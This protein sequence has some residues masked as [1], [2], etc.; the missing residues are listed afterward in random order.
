MNSMHRMMPMLWT[1]LAVAA[2]G[3]QAKEP[4][5]S[6]DQLFELDDEEEAPVPKAAPAPSPKATS[7]PSPSKASPSTSPKAAPAATANPS[8]AT[9]ASPAKSANPSGAPKPPGNVADAPSRPATANTAPAPT[10]EDREP[11]SVRRNTQPQATM[12]VTPQVASQQQDKT[13]RKNA[14]PV[15]WSGFAQEE[16]ARQYAKPSH[17][18][19]VRTRAQ[20][21]AQGQTGG[22]IKWK[23]GARVDYDAVFD[24]T[25]RYSDD[26]RKDRRLELLLRENYADIGAGP[27]ELR[28]GR[29]H[30]IWGE[31]VGLF[32]ADVVSARDTREFILTDFEFQRLPQWAIRAEHFQGDWHSEVIWI[33][34]ATLDEIGRY[35]DEF[36]PSLITDPSLGLQVRDRVKPAR[37]LG[38]SN[39]GLRTGVLKNGW[40][41]SAFYYSSID[42][43]PH[44]IRSIEN[45]PTPTLVFT[46]RHSRI[47]Q[48]GATL[49]KDF[50]RFVLKSEAVYTR[51]RKFSVTDFTDDDGVVR[52]NV[53]DYVVGIEFGMREQDVKFNAQVF[54]RRFLNYV[55]T[56]VPDHVETG[57]SFLVM[58][59]FGNLAPQVL[60]MQ[61][62]N[63]ND[64]LVQPSIDWN[65]A[66]NMRAR[67][68]L[69]I[70]SGPED[71]LFGQYAG[72]DRA[73]LEV[74]YS[75]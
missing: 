67:V 38:N 63:R 69:D 22:N 64:R 37:N 44:F 35:G 58:G 1:L 39:A 57:V 43:S 6:R 40:D 73:Y 75:F 48:T 61:S 71:G 17:W 18:T 19:K 29:Q 47:N 27:V 13:A 2:F 32:F 3:V 52:Q 45:L 11:V 16:V 23:L 5:A 9:A 20:L 68:G 36:H 25:D 56:L 34:Y 55:A 74:K 7:A 24:L 50:G 59:K 4:G 42:S 62:L 54:Q 66:K 72:R 30:I 21:N 65:F 15:R 53:L 8:P 51:G 12:P 46:P 10:A 31:V 70:L 28:I 60:V 14:S 33:P 26:V 41:I 49:A